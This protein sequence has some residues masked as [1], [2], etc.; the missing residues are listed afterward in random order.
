VLAAGS[1]GGGAYHTTSTCRCWRHSRRRG[2]EVKWHE[3][4]GVGLAVVY[5]GRRQGARRSDA[6]L[7]SANNTQVEYVVVENSQFPQKLAAAVEAKAPPDVVMLTAASNVIDYA[8]RTLLVDVSDVWKA[9][10][11]Q[12]GG[13]WGYVEPLYRIGSTYF[14]IPFEAETSPMFART[15][16]IK[17]ASGSTDPPKTLDELASVA[18]KVNSSTRRLRARVYA[19]TNARRIWQCH[20]HHLE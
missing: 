12:A 19:G 5:A 13:F 9:T 2:R 18:Q 11:T 20:G 7:G 17:Q 6:S 14:G 15:D 10:S 3:A 1:T 8:S 16:L 4:D